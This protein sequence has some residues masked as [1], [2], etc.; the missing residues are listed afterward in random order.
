MS[1]ELNKDKILL[2]QQDTLDIAGLKNDFIQLLEE[3]NI[4]Y[5]EYKDIEKAPIQKGERS[6]TPYVK[7]EIM[8]IFARRL[9]GD[10]VSKDKLQYRVK[11]KEITFE[12]TNYNELDENKIVVLPITRENYNIKDLDSGYLEGALIQEI[13]NLMLPLKF[14]VDKDVI[15]METEEE[16]QIRLKKERKEKV[17]DMN[18]VIKI[19]STKGYKVF[20]INN[21]DLHKIKNS[22]HVHT[23]LKDLFKKEILNCKEIKDYAKKVVEEN[24]VNSLNLIQE[25]DYGYFQKYINNDLA[26]KVFSLIGFNI[27]SMKIYKEKEEVLSFE[28]T[29]QNKKFNSI[30]RKHSESFNK[31]INFVSDFKKPNFD[32]YITQD[33]IDSKLKELK[34]KKPIIHYMFVKISEMYSYN[35]DEYS[36]DNKTGTNVMKDDLLKILS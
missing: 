6:Q 20:A 9:D 25:G 14:E 18:F 10:Y 13:G 1:K 5:Y 2:I 3:E 36:T 24:Y 15:A 4:L 17:I 33:I 27:K 7:K 21:K 16:K 29:I 22:K 26:V 31:I 28:N 32:K 12:E 30:F 8:N 11:E 35:F 23:T 19:L 34:V